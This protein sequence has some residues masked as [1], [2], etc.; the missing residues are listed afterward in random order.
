MLMTEPGF[1]VATRASY[2]TVAADYVTWFGGELAARPLDR[3]L[4]AG[5]A[6]LVRAAGAAPI[7]DIGCGPGRVTAHLDDIGSSAFGIDL[8]PQMVAL[9]RQAHP[10]LRFEVGSML[11]LD[12]PDRHLGGIVAWYSIIHVPDEQLP[13]AFAEF[14]RVL[15]PGGYL[16]VAFQVGS[17]VLHRADMAGHAVSLDFHP[18]QPDQVAELLRR[19]GLDVR[20][21]VLR[22]PDDGSEF[23]EK[24]QQAFLLARRSPA[25]AE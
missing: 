12:L 5:F 15:T 13:Q 24:T 11:A 7:A 6:E 16:L 3:A 20:L 10:N 2:D 25:S 17:E 23:P 4:L 8:S 18:R 14:C 19:A 22:E 21:R 9:A 1:V